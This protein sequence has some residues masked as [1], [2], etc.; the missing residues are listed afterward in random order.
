MHSKLA[1]GIRATLD[2]I[3]RLASENDTQMSHDEV[4]KACAVNAQ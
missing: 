4:F 2:K 1:D 3:D